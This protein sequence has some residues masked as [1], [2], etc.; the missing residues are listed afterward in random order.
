MGLATEAIATGYG[1][2]LATQQLGGLPA[3]RLLPGA[4]A[5]DD[6]VTNLV[7]Y[8]LGSHAGDAS[9]RANTAFAPTE[10]GMR[11]SFLGRNDNAALHLIVE[12]S[13][14]LEAD[15]WSETPN[16]AVVVASPPSPAP[17]GYAWYE[18]VLPAGDT[19]QF[20]RVRVTLTP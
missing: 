15:D 3:G 5:D 10:G 16:P 8:A 17:D 6:G 4:D 14:R 12:T 2:W 9:S 13:T 11:L 7:E 20:A 19:R 1:A 18:I